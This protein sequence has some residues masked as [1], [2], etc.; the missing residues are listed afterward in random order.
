MK[1]ATR[2]PERTRRRASRRRP[3]RPATPFPLR[4]E[5]PR[6]AP[7]PEPEAPR[8][9]SWLRR[10]IFAGV[11]FALAAGWSLTLRPQSLGGPAG[12]V[13][14]RGTSMLGTYDPGTLVL[15]H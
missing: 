11:I 10:I 1:T 13:M 6:P 2:V 7:L 15:V 9:R 3:I 4:I 12:Y 8:R 14:V 5:P